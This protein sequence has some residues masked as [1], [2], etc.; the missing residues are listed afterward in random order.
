MAAKRRNIPGTGIFRAASYRKPQVS[1]TLRPSLPHMAVCPDCL[2]HLGA[3]DGLITLP[4]P[5]VSLEAEVLPSP[6][7]PFTRSDSLTLSNVSGV[8]CVETGFAADAVSLACDPD[9]Q[10]RLPAWRCQEEDC[11]WCTRS[12]W[13]GPIPQE[14]EVWRPDCSIFSEEE[15]YWRR[16]PSPVIP[17][18]ETEGDI[19]TPP[20]GSYS[21]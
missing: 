17:F 4:P 7:V 12:T 10:E 9:G 16:T 18:E 20:S 21:R 3:A 14:D 8:S 5:A 6:V 2:F 19:L 11:V 15:G 1:I 13:T